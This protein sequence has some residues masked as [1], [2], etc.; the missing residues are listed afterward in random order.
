[1]TEWKKY[2]ATTFLLVV[3]V[4]MFFLMQVIYLGRATSAQAI[5]TFGGMYGEV[6]KAFPSQLWR[7]ITPIFVHIGWQHL[8]MNSLT[9]Y[10]LGH[11]AEDLWGSRRFLLLYLLAGIFGNL[12]TMSLTP[13]VLAAGASTS[14]FGLFG[15]I[16][17]VGYLAKNPYLRQLGR[18]YQTLLFINLLFNIFMPDV[19][20]VGHLGGLIGGVL[21]SL[22]I[23]LPWASTLVSVRRRWLA[24]MAYLILCL[25]LLVLFYLT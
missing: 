14:L 19:S 13:S 20:L 9:L 25:L 23:P 11:L 22:F 12:L 10:F 6:V 8:L 17:V 4:S 21:A 16:V 7:L 3:T 1:M 18:Q 2:P 5:F 15:A 24:G